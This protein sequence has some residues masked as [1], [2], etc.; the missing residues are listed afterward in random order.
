MATEH[1]SFF[2]FK[3]FDSFED[4]AIY[5]IEQGASSSNY[6]IITGEQNLYFDLDSNE[7]IDIDSIINYLISKTNSYIMVYESCDSIKYSYHIVIKGFHFSSHIECGYVAKS[8]LSDY[9]SFDRSVYTSRRNLRLLGSHKYHGTRIKRFRSSHGIDNPTD[10]IQQLLLSLVMHKPSNSVLKTIPIE[11][12]VFENIECPDIDQI[13]EQLEV[14][15]PNVFDIRQ[16]KGVMIVL[17]RLKAY[18]CDIC[19]RVHDT[20]NAVIYKIGATI[21]FKCYRDTNKTQLLNSAHTNLPIIPAQNQESINSLEKRITDFF[22][23]QQQ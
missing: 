4:F 10:P 14:H 2:T 8:L 20:E 11:K 13:K 12:R 18:H 16:I 19:G 3:N 23:Y 1:Q 6:E 17:K 7:P 9:P 22:L 21:Y 15:Y 5:H